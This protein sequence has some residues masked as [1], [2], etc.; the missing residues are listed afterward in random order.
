MLKQLA[1]EGLQATAA[2]AVTPKGPGAKKKGK[3]SAKKAKP[4]A[5]GS[6][7]SRS[8]KTEEIGPSGQTYTP[9][10]LQVG[11]I[12][13]LAGDAHVDLCRYEN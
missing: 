8:Q 2:E 5:A 3:A 10:E 9:F 7:R 12:A 11:S 4:P 13:V 1:N 6:S